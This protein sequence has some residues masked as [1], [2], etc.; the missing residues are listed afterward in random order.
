MRENDQ[1]TDDQYRW[2]MRAIGDITAR[3]TDGELSNY[4]KR[5]AIADENQRYYGDQA[6]PWMVRTGRRYE[7]PAVIAEAVGV[8]EDI[9]TI[10]LN[11]FRESGFEAYRDVIDS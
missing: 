6:E 1:H 9:M 10:A 3:W 4:D 2:H 7:A 8:D 11:V 5:R